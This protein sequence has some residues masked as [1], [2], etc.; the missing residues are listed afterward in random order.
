M[1]PVDLINAGSDANSSLGAASL[2]NPA[3]SLLARFIESRLE[4]ERSPAPLGRLPQ[5]V[6]RDLRPALPRI[7]MAAVMLY[8]HRK[9]VESYPLLYA[10]LALAHPN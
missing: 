3:P 6:R 8:A 5:G 9:A 10:T 4:S 7:G 1:I 2:A